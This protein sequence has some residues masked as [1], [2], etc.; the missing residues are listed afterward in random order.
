MEIRPIFSALMRNKTGLVLIALQVAI[1]L[2]IVTNSLFIIKERLALMNRPSGIDEAG[3]FT[4]SSLGFAPNFDRS[5]SIT[6]DMATLRAI[7]GVIDA[8]PIN[9][10][11]LSG[12]GWGEGISTK[13]L[14]P[15]TAKPEDNEGTTIYMV[16]DHGIDT[17]GL[18]LVEG[19]NFTAAEIEDRAEDANG[20]PSVVIIT[21]ALA[22]KL[23]P[24]EPTAVG[25]TVFMGEDDITVVGVVERLQAPWVNWD[26]VEHATLVPQRVL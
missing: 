23:F 12:G 15:E 6:A 18:N 19:R 8:T 11:P 1:T 26:D 13:K 9:N 24:D 20:W 16:D 17:M 14:D 7:P 2:A 22:K 10:L 25:K 3:L 5:A 21:K 4:V